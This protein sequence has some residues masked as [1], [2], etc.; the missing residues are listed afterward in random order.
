MASMFREL[1]S[2]YVWREGPIFW[3]VHLKDWLMH[4][5]G[6]KG[7]FENLWTVWFVGRTSAHAKR[8][9][10]GNDCPG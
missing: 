8:E 1:A 10:E 5:H 4:M 2:V 3:P 6:R 7:K 9:A